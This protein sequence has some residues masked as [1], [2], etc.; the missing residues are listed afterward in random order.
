MLFTATFFACS[1]RILE[2]EEA[3]DAERGLALCQSER[4]DCVVMELHLPDMSAFQVGMYNELTRP[5][6]TGRLKH[7]CFGNLA[8]YMLDSSIAEAAKKLGAQAML[9]FHW[10]SSPLYYLGGELWQGHACCSSMMN[11]WSAAL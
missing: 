10:L 7:L 1:S 2:A 3:E 8:C 11:P 6:Y 4:V 5:S 9:I